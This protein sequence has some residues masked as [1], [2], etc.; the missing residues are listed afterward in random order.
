MLDP[1]FI[2]RTYPPTPAYA[3]DREKIREF[4]AAVGADDPACHDVES[5]RALGHPDLV[6]PPTFAIVLSMRADEQVTSDPD[7]GLDY[8][9]VVHRE[10][11]LTHYRAIHAGDHLT[12]RVTVVDAKTVAGSD[13]LVTRE[14]IST[15]AGEEVCCLR[16]T[17]VAGGGS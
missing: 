12:V 10:Q 1:S 11:S 17:L 9:R 6:A 15:T 2:G 7:L 14:D 16:T 3:V 5:A 13:V 8:G 4:A